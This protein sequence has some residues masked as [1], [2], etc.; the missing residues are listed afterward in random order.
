MTARKLT[1]LIAKA[2]AT[3]NA[4]MVNPATAGPTTR[5]PL[6]IAEL[7]ETAFPMS[8]GPTISM[9]NDWRT[10]MSM[11]LTQ[12]RPSASATTIQISTMPLAVMT[13]RMMART[14]IAACTAISVWRLGRLSA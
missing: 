2:V 9:A 1:A 11:A 6:N 10:G 5:A 7:S 8:L 14:I 13:V 3:P 12:P 4:P